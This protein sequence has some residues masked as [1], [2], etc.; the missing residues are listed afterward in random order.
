MFGRPYWRFEHYTKQKVNLCQVFSL[1]GLIGKCVEKLPGSVRTVI[2]DGYTFENLADTPEKWKFAIFIV[3][4]ICNGL[5][6]NETT[7]K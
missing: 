3:L 4:H 2:Q 5:I 1:C 6:I 7:N